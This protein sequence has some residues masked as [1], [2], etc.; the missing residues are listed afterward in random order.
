ME[1][2]EKPGLV[3]E[4]V[5]HIASKSA[6]KGVDWFWRRT[7]QIVAANKL[8]AAVVAVLSLDGIYLKWLRDTP[9]LWAFAAALLL[10]GLA[11]LVDRRQR[12]TDGP[13]LTALKAEIEA[14]KSAKSPAEQPVAAHGALS[15]TPAQTTPVSPPFWWRD[16]LMV[17]MQDPLYDPSGRF[18]ANLFFRTTT[19]FP[20]NSKLKSLFVEARNDGKVVGQYRY[21][22]SP[23][24][25]SGSWHRIGK[26]IVPIKNELARTHFQAALARTDSPDVKIDL[27]VRYELVVPGTPDEGPEE[28]YVAGQ[29]CGIRRKGLTAADESGALPVDLT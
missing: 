5:R 9:E 13:T 20:S 27:L 14:L 11:L 28:R 10:L 23:M 6:E 16:Q 19:V 24:W 17:E 2:E 21:N 1:D 8:T 3:K 4:T 25:L 18:V 12:K 15:A 22:G 29:F 26:V 7:V